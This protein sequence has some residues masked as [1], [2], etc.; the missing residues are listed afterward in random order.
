MESSSYALDIAGTKAKFG[1]NFGKRFS[2]LRINQNNFENLLTKG[3]LTVQK[4]CS[5]AVGLS[6]RLWLSKIL[7]QAKAVVRP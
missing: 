6:R 5:K 2:K 4:I 3:S 1:K 7:G